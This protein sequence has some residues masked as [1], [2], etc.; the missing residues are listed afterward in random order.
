MLKSFGKFELLG[1]LGAGGMAVVYKARDTTLDRV[2][3]LK[4]INQ[5]LQGGEVAR[6]RFLQE[7]RVAAVLNHPNIVSVYELGL[8]DG[9]PFIAM[10]YLPGE[11]LRDLIEQGRPLTQRQKVNIALQIARAVEH[12][13]SRGVIHRDI[14]PGNIRI[15][16]GGGAKLMDFGIAKLTSSEL[17]GLTRTGAVMGTTAYMAPEQLRGEA[18]NVSGDV[19]AFG[20]VLYELLSYAKPFDAPHPAAIVYKILNV[21]P[22]RLDESIPETLRDLVE[23]CIK[24]T[25]EERPPGFTWIVRELTRIRRELRGGSGVAG[26]R[27]DEPILPGPPVEADPTPPEPVNV[28]ATR[29]ERR[30]FGAGDEETQPRAGT[31]AVLVVLGLLAVLGAGL[32]V[33]LWGGWVPLA[34]LGRGWNGP[35]TPSPQP[36]SA[37]ALLVPA[38]ETP[39]L[40][41]TATPSAIEPETTATEALVAAPTAS[42]PPERGPTSRPS[43]AAPEP[44]P[45]STPRA[46]EARPTESVPPA[47]SRVVRLGGAPEGTSICIDGQSWNAAR[48]GL[49]WILNDVPGGSHRIELLH[50]QKGT[51]AKTLD[52]GTGSDALVILFR[53]QDWTAPTFRIA[54][55]GSRSGVKLVAHRPRSG[56]AGAWTAFDPPVPLQPGPGGLIGLDRGIAEEYRIE[57]EPGKIL[58]VGFQW[59]GKTFEAGELKLEHSNGVLSTKRCLWRRP[60]SACGGPATLECGTL[61]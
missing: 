8:E 17:K 15:L 29:P 9:Y 20:L 52:V 37:P 51:A 6:M 42:P 12:A 49:A 53:D 3:A 16:E 25:A 2:V 28:V 60:E 34:W 18:P 44:P 30:L 14:K 39:A 21:E 55:S 10:E 11:D 32:G 19:F 61:D 24:K 57:L 48:A 41:P 40:G 33:G 1:E 45:T 31:S 58:T 13:H 59:I 43:P 7:A 36:T 27:T 5:R 26:E 22:E 35:P 38:T 4:V 56:A 54:L 46:P 50:R 47:Q 23:R